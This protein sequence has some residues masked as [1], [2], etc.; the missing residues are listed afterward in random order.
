MTMAAVVKVAADTGHGGG[1]KGEAAMERLAAR[2]EFSVVEMEG[3]AGVG[4]TVVESMVEVAMALALMEAQED[5]VEE[6]EEALEAVQVALLGWASRRGEGGG[7][8]GGGGDNPGTPGES[9]R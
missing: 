8:D 1:G 5:L 7:G 4:A 6:V 3:A 2:V 9:W